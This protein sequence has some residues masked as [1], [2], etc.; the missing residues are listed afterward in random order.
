MSKH[1]V[2]YLSAGQS[3]PVLPTLS[4]PAKNGKS[5]ERNFWRGWV[6][7]LVNYFHAENDA[8]S[9]WGG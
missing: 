2:D 7:R 9:A 8:V 4:M 5:D 6:P 1:R 3:K